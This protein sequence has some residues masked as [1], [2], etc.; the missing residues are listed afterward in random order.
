MLWTDVD[1]RSGTILV[2]RAKV[3]TEEKERT[4]T[5]RERTV[6]LNKRAAAV[7]DRQ[8]ARTQ[9]GTAEVFRNPFTG[10]PGTTSRNSG[11]NGHRRCACWASGTA[12]RKSCATR[13][14][15][16]RCRLAPTPSGWP[17]STGITCR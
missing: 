11:V 3:M 7:I 15:R 10:G 13:R 1:L 4:K 14:S 6:E 5:Y 17:T 8:R 2:R 16:W 9:V 12:R